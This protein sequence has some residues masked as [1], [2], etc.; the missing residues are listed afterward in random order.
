LSAERICELLKIICLSKSNFYQE[1][2]ETNDVMHP[3][4]LSD[5][6]TRRV[7][8][9]ERRGWQGRAFFSAE[10]KRRSY[11]GR[12][13]GRKFIKYI[14]FSHIMEEP[15]LAYIDYTICGTLMV[16]ELR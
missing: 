7:F 4:P 11:D 1:I 12:K 16:M 2:I 10:K 14:K 9:L 6:K 5:P 3:C 15:K 13:I 8:W